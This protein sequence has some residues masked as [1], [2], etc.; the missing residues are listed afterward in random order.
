MFFNKLTVIND[1]IEVVV[2]NFSA[3]DTKFTVVGV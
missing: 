1:L 3:D 2:M